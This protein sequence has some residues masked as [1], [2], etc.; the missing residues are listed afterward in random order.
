M[1]EIAAGPEHCAY[2][3]SV[4]VKAVGHPLSHERADTTPGF[5]DVASP[6]FVTW[7]TQLSADAV[8]LRG[9]IGTFEPL[10]LRRALAEYAATAALRDPRFPPVTASELA[11]LQ[12]GVSLLVN[13]SPRERWDD[14]TI[15]VHGIRIRFALSPG[16][17][18]SGTATFLPEVAAEQ[19]W[20]RFETL[21][22]LL[23]KGG[24]HGPITAAVLDAVELTRYESSKATMAFRDYEAYLKAHP[25]AS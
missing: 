17:P 5:A 14:W 24:Y 21:E 7:N 19:G 10:P 9:C 4:L 8:R 13:F 15:G 22:H 1:A 18:L 6:L 16:G 25:E 23:R 11:S 2:C 12:C 3:F 20:T